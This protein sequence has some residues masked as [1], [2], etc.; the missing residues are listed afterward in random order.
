[1][2]VKDKLEEIE[3][4][5]GM[6]IDDIAIQVPFGDLEIEEAVVVQVVINFNHLLAL[7]S[8]GQD[9]ALII[10][11]IFVDDDDE[12]GPCDISMFG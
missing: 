8:H 9:I 4:K 10:D 7:N 12:A 6:S 5:Y 11:A 3:A 1:M 2:K